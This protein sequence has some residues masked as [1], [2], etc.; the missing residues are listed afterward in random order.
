MKIRT[1]SQYIERF[2]RKPLARARQLRKD[3]HRSLCAKVGKYIVGL[4]VTSPPM[5][6]EN[7]FVDI[8]DVFNVAHE[9]RK[10]LVPIWSTS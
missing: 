4:P 1:H 2:N 9:D 8:Q 5:H 3:G 10:K 7:Y 6:Y